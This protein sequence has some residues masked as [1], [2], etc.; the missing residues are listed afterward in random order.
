MRSKLLILL[1][2]LCYSCSM[3]A[4]W[5]SDEKEPSAFEDTALE[6]E[7]HQYFWNQL[8]QGHYDSLD[9]V[10]DKLHYAYMQDQQDFKLAAH[11]GF[12]Y[13]WKVTERQRMDSIRP[14]IVRAGDLSQRYFEEA[15]ALNPYDPRLQGFKAGLML[16]NGSRHAD[17]KLRTRGYFEGQ[18]AIREWPSFN[19]FSVGYVMS[20]IEHDNERYDEALEYQWQNLEACLCREIDQDQPDLSDIDKIPARVADDYKKSR[21]CTNS[22][23]APHNVEGFLLNLGDMLVKKGDTAQAREVYESI[24]LI[25]ESDAWP[26]RPQLDNRLANLEENV[27]KFRR[28]GRISD[29]QRVFIQTEFGCMGCHQKSEAEFAEQNN[30]IPLGRETYFLN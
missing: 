7:A 15:V 11:L 24:S 22:W 18:E 1:S 16:V 14:S 29:N 4:V 17:E 30:S 26:Y 12:A 28:Q 3:V 6:T 20:V 2:L 8:H 19:L 9:K 25:A 5:F 23:I 13:V 27:Q 10:L 21:A